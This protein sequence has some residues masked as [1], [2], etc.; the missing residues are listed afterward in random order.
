[1]R[2][3]LRC[4]L[5]TPT[6]VAVETIRKPKRLVVE[7]VAVSR[8]NKDSAC[9]NVCALTHLTICAYRRR[10]DV[11]PAEQRN[12]ILSAEMRERFAELR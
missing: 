12:A 8:L 2:P 10:D 9:L 1:M 11:V 6:F 5:R 7:L 3:E 4:A